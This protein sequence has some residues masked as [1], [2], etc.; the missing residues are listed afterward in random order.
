MEA[1]KDRRKHERFRV[2]NLSCMII[3]PILVLSYEVLD[4]SNSGLAF[5]YVGWEKWPAKW[6]RLDIIDEKFYLKDIPFKIIKDVQLDEKSKTLSRC[7]I[8]FSALKDNQKAMLMQYIAHVE[9]N[10]KRL[11]SKHL[12]SASKAFDSELQ[13]SFDVER[14]LLPADV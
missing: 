10:D 1:F 8:K 13:K 6:I 11:S 2:K 9:A 12:S 5:S 14:L 4:I 7:S 3:T